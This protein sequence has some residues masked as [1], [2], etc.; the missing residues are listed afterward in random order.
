[1]RLVTYP[2][3]A[4]YA[5][6]ALGLRAVNGFLAKPFLFQI[7][8]ALFFWPCLARTFKSD[9]HLG[10]HLQLSDQGVWLPVSC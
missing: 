8:G 6:D 4:T 1:M 2:Y 5:Y 3:Q 9:Y 10:G 7:Q